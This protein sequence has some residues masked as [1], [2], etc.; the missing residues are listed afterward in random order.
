MITGIR[1]TVLFHRHHRI[2]YAVRTSGF[3]RIR[4]GRLASLYSLCRSYEN[5]KHSEW[6]HASMPDT[7]NWIGVVSAGDDLDSG[8]V[9]S[10]SKAPLTLYSPLSIICHPRLLRWPLSASSASTLGR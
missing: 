9:A 10:V 6:S 4:G 2:A 1:K 8:C 7:R 3:M 5:K